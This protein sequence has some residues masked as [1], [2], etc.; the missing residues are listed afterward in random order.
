MA[1]VEQIEP[2]LPNPGLSLNTERSPI[3][4]KLELDINIDPLSNITIICKK[5]YSFYTPYSL[6]KIKKTAQNLIMCPKKP[7]SS[8]L[9]F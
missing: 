4:F 9:F 6:F 1:C 5:R 8:H 7:K 2:K 3:P